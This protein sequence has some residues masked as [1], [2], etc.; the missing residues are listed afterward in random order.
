LALLEGDRERA[1]GMIL[2]AARDSRTVP[3]LVLGVLAPAQEEV[4]RM[5][6]A[7]EVNVA[8]EHFAT[9]TTKAVMAELSQLNHHRPT[10]GKTVLAAAVTGNYHDLGLHMVSG[11]FENYGWRSIQLG[12]D[13]PIS[14][15]VQSVESFEVDLLLL[16]A[17]LSTQLPTLKDT[18]EAVRR[19]GP[20]GAKVKILVGGRAFEAAGDLA[21][22]LGADAYTANA[23]E[24]VAIGNRLVGLPDPEVT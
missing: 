7:G 21:P 23:A 14:D 8:E 12:A 13:V 5:W 11:L 3:G 16:S 17:A 6:L 1:E 15:L 2:D 18:I 19:G 10:H 9:A 20:Q 22:E 4:G 24:A